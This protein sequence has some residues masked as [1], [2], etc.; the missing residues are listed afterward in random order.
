MYST[1]T[2]MMKIFHHFSRKE[3]FKMEINQHP[4]KW[5]LIHF[6]TFGMNTSSPAKSYEGE[7]I[8]HL[9]QTRLNKS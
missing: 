1:Y 4:M 7:A 6:L 9:K 8:V 2:Q 5:I 3:A